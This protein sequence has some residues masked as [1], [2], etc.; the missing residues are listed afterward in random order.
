MEF[1]MTLVQ[2]MCEEGN[3]KFNFEQAEGLLREYKNLGGVQFIVFPELFA[4]GFRHEDYEQQGPGIPGPTSKFICK[5][6]KKFGAYVFGTDIERGEQRYY[7][8][9]VGAGPSGDVIG[10]YRKI[11]PFQEERDVFNGGESIVLMECGGIKVGV[12]ICYDIRF[13]ELS[14][15]LAI[16]GAE[17]LIIPA[18][19]PDPRSTHW[20]TLI[21]ARAIENQLYVAAANRIGFGFD[22]KIYFGH[23]Q[24]VDPWGV[25]LTRRSS[26]YRIIQVTGD[27][28]MIN[29]V[30]EQITCYADRS[31][32]GYNKVEWFRE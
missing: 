9:L 12:Q 32:I 23:S 3:R 2:L 19:F 31:P 28:Q 17:I 13:P 27:T 16:E 20:N 10:T 30:R 8:T 6:A 26:E 25:I 21:Q 29:S 4:I 14:R 24:V 18:A 1:T 5:I 15:K 11:H 22:K 7:N